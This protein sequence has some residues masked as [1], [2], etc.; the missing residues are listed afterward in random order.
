MNQILLIKY[1][2]EVNSESLILNSRKDII[3]YYNEFVYALKTTTI[4]KYLTINNCVL[5]TKLYSF[6]NHDKNKENSNNNDKLTN[7]FTYHLAEGIKDNTSIKEL[8]ISL[9]DF[10]DNGAKN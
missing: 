5:I 10:C 6:F 8:D 1:S 3:S 4:L 7:E 2:D 9:N